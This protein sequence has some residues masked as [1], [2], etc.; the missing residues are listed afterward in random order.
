VMEDVDLLM[1][2]LVECLV[3]H[4]SLC[5]IIFISYLKTHLDK[6]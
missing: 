1:I 5:D 6:R 3:S 4:Y 2:V